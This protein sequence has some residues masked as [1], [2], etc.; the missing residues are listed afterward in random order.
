MNFYLKTFG[1]QMNDH[2]S[3]L[4][5]AL[6]ENAGHQACEVLEE[7]DIIV[8]NT[9]CVRQSAEDRALGFIGSI[10]SLK[11]SKPELV[12]VVCG[13]M[14]QQ[15]QTA[16][17]L[18]SKYHHIGIII[19]TFAAAFL[20]QYIETYAAT[21]RTIVDIAERYDS[22]G[23]ASPCSGLEPDADY[24]ARVNINFGCNNYCSYCIVP[25]V[26]GRERSRQPEEILDEINRLAA[27][28]VREVQLLGQN[29]NSYGKDFE[30]G[31]E[32]WNFAR[33]LTAV[34]NIG[35]IERI[36][37]MTSHPR[38]FD[39]QLAETISILPKVCHHYH[40]PV[41]SGSDRLLALM[42]RG[43][44]TDEYLRKLAL[45]RKLTPD[46]AITTDIIVGF[47]GESEE[48][49][50]HTLDFLREAHFDAAYTFI[51][52]RRSGTKAAEMPGH[53]EPEIKKERLQLLMATQNPISLA[54]NKKLVGTLQQVMVEGASRTHPEMT[55][56]RNDGNKIVVFPRRPGLRPGDLVTI[57]ITAAQTW[58]LSG[59]AR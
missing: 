40:L 15:E 24:K 16:E 50:H 35:G 52:S 6:L 18:R 37:Y 59:I 22:L 4:I 23:Q 11:E 42:N 30:A 58:N 33:L 20:P 27:A 57:K 12:I 49:F 31:A 54:Q 5:A 48:D 9:C 25:Y 45:I 46:A 39:R 36:R 19:G 32:G 47:P 44:A 41:Q 34:S 29:V 28:G 56:G 8:V 38:D 7:A 43:Y 3:N 21:G 1:C 14:S 51:Y 2:D 53:L 26:R 55:S 17:L 13:C 10:K